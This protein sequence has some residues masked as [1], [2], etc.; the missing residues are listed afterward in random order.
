MSLLMDAL[1][2]AEEA[3]RQAS[4]NQRPP[5]AASPAELRLDPLETPPS[6]ATQPQPSLS[7]ELASVDAGLTAAATSASPRRRPTVPVA[8]P[9]ETDADALQAAERNAARNVFAVKQTPPSRTSLWLFL[10]LIG[11]ASLLIGGYF[12]WQLQSMSAGSLTAPTADRRPSLP[13]ASPAGALPAATPAVAE[14]A[15]AQPSET[16]PVD[17]SPLPAAAARPAEPSTRVHRPAREVARSPRAAEASVFQRSSGR[18]QAAQTLNRAYQ[19]WQADRLDEALQA[20]EQVLRSDPKNTDALLGVAA[21]AARQGQ[22]ERAH[23]FYLRVLESDPTDVT[24]Q[25]ALINLRGASDATRSESRLKT[26]LAGQPGSSALYFALGN[27]YGGQQ[28]WNEAQQAYFQAYALEPGNADYIFNVAVSLDHL[29]QKK[30]AA[31]YYEMALSAAQT[32]PSA[33][34]K[35]AAAQRILELQR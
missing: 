12:W 31:Q 26:L 32:W 30:L 2:R 34:D 27:L 4:A 17:G 16:T 19:A 18:P 35:N 6:P 29:R 3:K 15:A 10:G 21:I 11:V 22:P 1:R 28:R 7:E 20:Y 8:P 9:A 5:I 33:F 13:P 24:A 23:S 25:A 14:V